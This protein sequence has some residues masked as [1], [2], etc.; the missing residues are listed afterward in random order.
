MESTASGS[1]SIEMGGGGGGGGG[2]YSL[3]GRLIEE[4]DISPFK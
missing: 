2:M 4:K 3:I 1:N